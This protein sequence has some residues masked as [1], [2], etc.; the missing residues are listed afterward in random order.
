MTAPSAVELAREGLALE[1]K[2]AVG[3]RVRFLRD[4][5]KFVERGREGTIDVVH[6]DGESFW[7]A[8]DCGGFYGW[9]ALDSWE[10]LTAPL[11]KQGAKP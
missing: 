1:E 10:P 9:T 7:V 4:D 2:P 8:T 11:D 5:H 6:T 3:M